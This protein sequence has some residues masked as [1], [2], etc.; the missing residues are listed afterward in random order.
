MGYVHAC[1]F[2]IGINSSVNIDF[3]VARN[4]IK[5]KNLSAACDIK[6]FNILHRIIIW[7][8]N[9]TII[10]DFSVICY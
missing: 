1:I 2:V 5:E 7:Q 3:N 8:K 6:I 4:T 10:Y 9:G